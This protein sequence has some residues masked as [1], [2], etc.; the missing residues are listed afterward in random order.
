[1]LVHWP[2]FDLEIGDWRCFQYVTRLVEHDQCSHFCPVEAAAFQM[3]LCMTLLLAAN[4]IAP[5]SRM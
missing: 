3:V 4:R 5:C 1:M 2:L